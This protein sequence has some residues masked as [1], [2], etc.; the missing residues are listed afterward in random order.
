MAQEHHPLYVAPT[1]ARE[2][3]LLSYAG[4]ASRF[5]ASLNPF[6]A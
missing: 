1:R 5:L 2:W 6:T 3:P 4:E